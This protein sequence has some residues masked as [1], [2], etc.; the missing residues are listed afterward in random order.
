MMW[1][2]LTK[3]RQIAGLE[4]QLAVVEERISTET[5]R[6]V[7]TEIRSLTVSV[8]ERAEETAAKLAE[9]TDRI[10]SIE[11]QLSTE[12]ERIAEM[13]AQ[14]DAI[15][16]KVEEARYNATE[17][18]RESDRFH[19][20]LSAFREDYERSYSGLLQRLPVIRDSSSTALH[21][22]R[23]DFLERQ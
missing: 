15:T 6:L 21:G 22:E 12:R 2:W 13:S 18:S 11:Q 9:M 23:R 3:K 7:E 19:A 1:E 10:Q 20:S 16:E 8:V 4:R 5:R 14:L 17:L